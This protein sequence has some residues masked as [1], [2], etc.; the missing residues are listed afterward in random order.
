M[1]TD[2]ATILRPARGDDGAAVFEVTRRAIGALAKDHYS[3]E[4]IDRWMGERTPAF[5]EAVIAGGC[6]VVADRAG[7]VIGFVD[8]E[9]GEL[10]RLFV[11]PEVAGAGL[12]ARLLKVGVEIARLGHCG[13]IRVEATLNAESFY[14]RHGFRRIGVADFSHGLG[15]ARIEIVLME[16]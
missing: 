11:L 10:T 4:Q 12:G 2:G 3:P 14:R 16:L 8:A 5:Y 1:P 15:G 6:M 13:P 7:A 9:P